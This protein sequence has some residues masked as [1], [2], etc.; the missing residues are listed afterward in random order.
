M[1]EE[2]GF[3]TPAL[4]VEIQ[5]AGVKT[6]LLRTHHKNEKGEPFERLQTVISNH[7]VDAAPFL[8]FPPIEAGIREKVHYP[9]L[10]AILDEGLDKEELKNRLM[11]EKD[12]LVPLTVYIED[13]IASVNYGVNLCGEFG[14]VDDID[15]LGN[16]RVRCVGR[17]APEPAARRVFAYGTRSAREVEHSGSGGRDAHFP[18]QY[19]PGN[20]G[21]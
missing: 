13:I 10:R 15:H 12:K 16:R 20:G 7:F 2:G 14:N 9:T 1:L 3:I 6:V 11:E 5:N 19:T 17:T 18:Y 4:A 8:P 21:C